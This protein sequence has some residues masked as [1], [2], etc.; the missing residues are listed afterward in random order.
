MKKTFNT[1]LLIASLLVGAIAL[2]G[3]NGSASNEKQAEAAAAPAE[4]SFD[5]LK[6]NKQLL[7]RFEELYKKV[8]ARDKE[9]VDLEKEFTSEAYY[10]LYEELKQEEAGAGI[11]FIDHD[12]WTMTKSKKCAQPQ[13][14]NIEVIDGQNAIINFTIPNPGKDAKHVTYKMVYERDNWF[15]DDIDNERAEMQ[16]FINSI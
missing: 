12:H 9:A 7:T 13:V 11:K 1:C 10:K 2:N 4:E 8:L 6:I 15:I 5:E 14:D 16:D 3:C